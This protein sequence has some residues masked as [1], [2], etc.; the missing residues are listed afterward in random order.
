MSGFFLS[1]DWCGVRIGREKCGGVFFNYMIVGELFSKVV[2]VLCIVFS[3]GL[4]WVKELI[5]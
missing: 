1:L 2:Y 4:G 5:F 3:G